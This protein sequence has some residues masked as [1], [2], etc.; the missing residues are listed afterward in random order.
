MQTFVV[1]TIRIY[2]IKRSAY[3]SYSHNKQKSLKFHTGITSKDPALKFMT[4]S[5]IKV[6]YIF[7]PNCQLGIT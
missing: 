1:D 4:C 7:I 6:R 5:M 2:T 3:M